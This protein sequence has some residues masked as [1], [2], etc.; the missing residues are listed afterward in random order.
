MSFDQTQITDLDAPIPGEVVAKRESF[1]YLEGWYVINRAN[2]I[3]G[4]G[5]WSTSIKS[6]E[7]VQ[8][9]QKDGKDPA[10]PKNWWVGYLVTAEVVLPDGAS[11]Q[12]IGFG[13]GIDKDLGKAHESAT[14]E[15][16]TDAVKRC[17]KNTGLSMGLALYDKSKSGV[18]KKGAAPKQKSDIQIAKEKLDLDAAKCNRLVARVVEVHRLSQQKATDR[19]M[20]AIIEASHNGSSILALLDLEDAVA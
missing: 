2:Q 20:N 16:V 1:D 11:Y 15:A 17:L 5:K 19:V 13:Q 18:A 3:F 12:D 6:T 10:K 8:M 14:K 4:H 9:E 7:R